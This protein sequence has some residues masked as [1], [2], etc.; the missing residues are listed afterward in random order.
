MSSD[1]VS[2]PFYR[3]SAN[4]VQPGMWTYSR[5]GANSD[6]SKVLGAGIESWDYNV[7]LDFQRNFGIDPQAVL[8]DCRLQ[9]EATLVVMVLVSTAGQRI[10]KRVSTIEF[11]CHKGG[12][13]ADLELN[14]HMDGMTLQRDLRL[15]TEICVKKA[16]PQEESDPFTPTDSGARI[17]S[18][19]VTAALEGS[20]SRFPMSSVSFRQ[21]FGN[22][23][24]AA[25]MLHWSPDALESNAS[26]AIRLYLNTDSNLFNEIVGCNS[27]LCKVVQTDVLRQILVALIADPDFDLTPDNWPQ[28]S[29]GNLV[30][31][32]ANNIF[33]EM[34]AEPLRSRARA[35][36]GWVDARIQSY[37][38]LG[39]AS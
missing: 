20:L 21:A 14:F 12:G 11:T 25:W 32:W 1:A 4:A 23:G 18:D 9:E 16:F 36:P 13:I 22:I 39:N 5:T 8:D 28:Y 2:F 10:R 17:W 26:S 24:D 7:D 35:D 15:D 34:S 27:V 30:A 31:Q 3:L 38:G 19:S 29:L 6:E 37:M 33:G